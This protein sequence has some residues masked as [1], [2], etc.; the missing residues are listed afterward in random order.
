MALTCLLYVLVHIIRTSGG[1]WNV[2]VGYKINLQVTEGKRQSGV[3][4]N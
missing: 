3:A 4:N 2:I 1:V